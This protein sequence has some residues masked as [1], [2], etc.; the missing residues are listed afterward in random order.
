LSTRRFRETILSGHPPAVEFLCNS[1]LKVRIVEYGQYFFMTEAHNAMAPVP[2]SRKSV[3]FVCAVCLL[4]LVSVFLFPMSVGPYTACHG[5]ATALK[6]IRSIQ[7]ILL[8]IAMA[9][10]YRHLRSALCIQLS[11]ISY[12]PR[13]ASPKSHPSLTSPLLC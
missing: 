12:I 1:R 9:G 13:R 5:P 10:I 11:C 3:L 2:R 7:L 6:A 4:S 8:S